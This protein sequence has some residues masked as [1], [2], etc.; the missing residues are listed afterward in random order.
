L[1]LYAGIL[2][3]EAHLDIAISSSKLGLTTKNPSIMPLPRRIRP[4]LR[5]LRPPL[6]NQHPTKARFFTRNAQLLILSPPVPRPQLAFLGASSSRIFK[7]RAA[8]G[9]LSRLISTETKRYLK[10]QAWQGG[11][12]TMWCS[13]FSV[14]GLAWAYGATHEL[15]DREFPAP[16]DWTH[17]SRFRYHS[18]KALEVPEALIGV[19]DWGLVGQAWK[20]LLERLENEN[21]DGQGLLQQEEGGILVLGVGQIGLDVTAKSEPWRRGYYEA[22]MGCGKAAEH[23]DGKVMDVTRHNVFPAEYVIGPS[24]PNPKPTP[25]WRPSAPLEEN[26]IPAYEPPET[27]YL[28]V[29]TTK[30]FTT[31]QRLNAAI[32]YAE[33]LD[34]KGMHETAEEM[35]RWGTDIASATL[36]TPASVIDS[37]TGTI[38]ID[39]PVITE[40]VLVAATALAVHHAQ[41]NNASSALPILLSVLRARRTAPVGASPSTTAASSQPKAPQTDIDAFANIMKSLWSLVQE[42]KYPPPSPSG[43]ELLQRTPDEKCEEAT[44][45]VYIGEVLFASSKAQHESGIA[46]TRDAVDLAEKCI[47]DPSVSLGAKRKSVDCLK[48]GLENWR[49]MVE[50]ATASLQVEVKAQ[51]DDGWKSWIEHQTGIEQ[52]RRDEA[53]AQLE[54][55]TGEDKELSKRER[56]IDRARLLDLF[57]RD[58][59]PLWGTWLLRV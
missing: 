14:L 50:A 57:K 39:A 33:W 8:Q 9:K 25:P 38:K 37:R 18:A 6:H 3:F 17:L 12:W 4:Q 52:K 24:N 53:K 47:R 36:P 59:K 58:G 10:E 32:A 48:V 31:N 16:P 2:G 35:I 46:W 43:D 26:C 51:R 21:I 5:P 49:A 19:V 23:L 56:S 44:V 55:W 34:F 45:M 1:F 54:R 41:T 13:I 7:Q 22:L 30:G 42:V 29:I 20:M 27:Y 15:L 11:K 28:K 40:N